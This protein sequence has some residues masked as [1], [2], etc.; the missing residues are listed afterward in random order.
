MFYENS[1]YENDFTHGEK[2]TYDWFYFLLS[3][4]LKDYLIPKAC[5]NF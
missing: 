1:F 5:Y 3:R 2:N 4:R